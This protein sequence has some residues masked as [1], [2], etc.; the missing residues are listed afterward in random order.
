MVSGQVVS[1]DAS[2]SSANY[3]LGISNVNGSDSVTRNWP[4]ALSARSQ[5]VTGCTELHPYHWPYTL[6]IS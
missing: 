6:K 4:E 5:G 1:M 2:S 3:V